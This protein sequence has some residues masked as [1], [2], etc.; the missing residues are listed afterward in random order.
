M[1]NKSKNI[2]IW[3]GGSR[4]KELEINEKNCKYIRENYYNC[5]KNKS[6][7]SKCDRIAS[8]FFLCSEYNL[9]LK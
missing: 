8:Q 7:S 2:Q 4:I 5:I 9:S 3:T 6:Y 1:E